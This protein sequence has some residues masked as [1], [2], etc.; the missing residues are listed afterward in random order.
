MSTHLHFAKSWEVTDKYVNDFIANVHENVKKEY[1]ATE[2]LKYETQKYHVDLPNPKSRRFISYKPYHQ[3]PPSYQLTTIKPSVLHLPNSLHSTLYKTSIY[4]ELIQYPFSYANSINQLYERYFLYQQLVYKH[5][6]Y[7]YSGNFGRSEKN[8][9]NKKQKALKS[10]VEY[11][12]TVTNKN[13][14]DENFQEALFYPRKT[15]PSNPY[16]SKT[17]KIP[18]VKH[19]TS[20]LLP[21]YVSTNYNKFYQQRV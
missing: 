8:V 21:G 12:S 18:K 16:T 1:S 14:K 20:F 9:H 4:N 2:P 17:T 3:K 15:Y 19:K 11:L 7:H 6:K 5:P 13:K 10:A